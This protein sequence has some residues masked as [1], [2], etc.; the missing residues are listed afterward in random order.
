MCPSGRL[1]LR[2]AAGYLLEARRRAYVIIPDQRYENMK[3]KVVILTFL[4]L[5]AVVPLPAQQTKTV[6][7]SDLEKYREKR[8][9]AERDYNENYARMGFP[10]PD[11]LQKQIEKSRVEREALSARLTS[12]RIQQEQADAARAAAA[13]RPERNVYV[14]SGVSPVIGGYIYSYPSLYSYWRRPRPRP[15]Y[16]TGIRPASVMGSRS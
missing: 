11:E 13:S 5:L 1:T 10:S 7:N 3:V 8:L 12:E 6:T 4:V 16:P 9:R 14:V 15:A 2:P